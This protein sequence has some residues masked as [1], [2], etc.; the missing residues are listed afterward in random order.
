MTDL[1][2]MLRW[3]S[4]RSIPGV[5]A[6]SIL[7][8]AVLVGGPALLGRPP[9]HRYLL[10]NLALAWVPFVAA[11]GIEGFSPARRRVLLAACGLAWLLFLPNAPYLL[12]DLSHLREPSVTPW[13]DLSRFVAF[14]WAGCALGLASVRIVQR[15]VEA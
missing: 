9:T 3:S 13:L 14:A 2:A 5:L 15:I 1:R 7:A 10:W 11:L 8:V 4:E 6:A 12:S